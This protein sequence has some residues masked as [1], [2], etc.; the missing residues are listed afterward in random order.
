MIIV[1]SH[2]QLS[3]ENSVNLLSDAPYYTT[4]RIPAHKRACT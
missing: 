4:Y 2:D 3:L 1:K